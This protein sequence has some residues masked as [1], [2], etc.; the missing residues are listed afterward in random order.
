MMRLLHTY[1][2]APVGLLKDE[3]AMDYFFPAVQADFAMEHFLQSEGR[4]GA[5][6][7]VCVGREGDGICPMDDVACLAFW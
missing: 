1:K 2:K 7:V 4:N 6:S 5:I 3:Q